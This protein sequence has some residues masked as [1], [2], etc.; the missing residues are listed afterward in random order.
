MDELAH[1]LAS[2]A[3]S[4]VDPMLG[5]IVDRLVETYKPKRIYLFGSA[6]SSPW[7]I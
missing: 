6:A 2:P 4:A 1:D 5:T 3:P 7:Q